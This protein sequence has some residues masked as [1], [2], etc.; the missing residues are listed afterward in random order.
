MLAKTDRVIRPVSYGLVQVEIAIPDLEI[1]AT[2]RIRAD[3]CLELNRR[4]LATEVGE[5]DKIT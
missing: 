1:E 4:A 3:P 2:F 5:R